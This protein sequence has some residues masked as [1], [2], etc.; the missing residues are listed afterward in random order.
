M[1]CQGDGRLI[2]AHGIHRSDG[3]IRIGNNKNDGGGLHRRMVSVQAVAGTTGNIRVIIR[4]AVVPVSQ[5]YL[6][7]LP[8]QL[9][10]GNEDDIGPYA[11]AGDWTGKGDDII[12]KR[13]GTRSAVNGDRR[14]RHGVV[15][16]VDPLYPTRA[17]IGVVSLLR[18]DTVELRQV[19]EPHVGTVAETDRVNGGTDVHVPT[20]VVIVIPD[21]YY[22]FLRGGGAE[23]TVH[24]QGGLRMIVADTAGRGIG[25]YGGGFEDT[26][27]GARCRNSHHSTVVPVK[28]DAHR[29]TCIV[30]ARIADS[31]RG[32]D[33]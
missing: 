22:L 17:Y 25:D 10:V 16:A 9:V 26:G 21:G 15:S 7:I 18:R 20:V 30:D 11:G 6:K 14:S 31:P 32:S 3:G 2:G 13:K 23:N 28:P 8:Y 1:C 19:L 4:V 27:P 29:S 33:R 5:R 24:H 12:G